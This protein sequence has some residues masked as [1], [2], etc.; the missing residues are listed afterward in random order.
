MPKKIKSLLVAFQWL[1]LT[2]AIAGE[3]SASGMD[4]LKAFLRETHSARVRFQQTLLDR[5]L[6]PRE[7]ARGVLEFSRPG[8][9]RWTYEQPYKQLI[10]GDSR[11]VWVYDQDLH[12]VTVKNLDE[13]LGA[14]PA[15]LLAT[16]EDIE[17]RFSLAA[18]ENQGG[19]EWVEATP[20]EPE[21]S[22]ER[23]RLGFDAAGLRT[24][25]LKDRFGQ[26]TVI[27]FSDFQRNLRLPA[28]IF[29]FTPPA[30]TDVI[31]A[32]SARSE[33]QQ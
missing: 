22:F 16:A 31:G 10:V 13:T 5:N 1:L 24:M 23:M 18:L 17:K 20:K 21:A 30:G 27:R 28:E 3:A 6:K 15:A 26:L 32:P 7:E 11:K 8:K 12:Q 25:E 33:P 2:L 19:L 29:R 4:R 9:F 14:S